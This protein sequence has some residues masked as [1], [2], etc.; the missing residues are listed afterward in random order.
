MRITG[1]LDPSRANQNAQNIFAGHIIKFIIKL[2]YVLY[3]NQ[4]TNL[5][6]YLLTNLLTD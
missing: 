5:L 3:K 4:L 1:Y 6:S 2:K